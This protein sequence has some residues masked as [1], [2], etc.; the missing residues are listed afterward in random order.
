MRSGEPD[1]RLRRLPA[2]NL[3]CELYQAKGGF[4]SPQNI[5]QSDDRIEML[6][7]VLGQQV[8]ALNKTLQMIAASLQGL[9][10]HL[11]QMRTRIYVY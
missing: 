3:F 1:P 2:C 10:S 5:P 6:I 7:A 4:M 9:E 8:N 11:R